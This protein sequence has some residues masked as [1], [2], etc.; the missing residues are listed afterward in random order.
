MNLSLILAVFGFALLLMPQT[1]WM[2]LAVLAIGAVS[3]MLEPKPAAGAA[4]LPGYAQ[5]ARAARPGFSW[6]IKD[7]RKQ[8]MERGNVSKFHQRQSAYMEDGKFNI[9]L[10]V[11]PELSEIMDLKY[12]RPVKGKRTRIERDTD[13]I[14]FPDF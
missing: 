5:P 7:P 14:L 2:G 6:G 9:P 11:S 13:N 8:E 4:V 1:S 10:P 12:Q 3:Y